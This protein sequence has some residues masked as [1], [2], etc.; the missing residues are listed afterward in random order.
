MRYAFELLEPLLGA[1]AEAAAGRWEEVTEALGA[2]QDSRM[3]IRWIRETEPGFTGGVLVGMELAR[4]EAA[5]Q[6]LPEL[7]QDP[8]RMLDRLGLKA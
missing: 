7:L 6:D 3:T 4:V 8:D 2:V 1:Q 5:R